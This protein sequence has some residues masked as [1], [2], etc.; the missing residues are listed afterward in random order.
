MHIVSLGSNCYPAT[1]I[2]AVLNSINK[3]KETQ[4]FDM[5]G[6]SMWSINQLIENRFEGIM[7]HHLFKDIV[8][9]EGGGTIV[10]NTR[11]NLRFK[12]DLDFAIQA[13][14]SLSFQAKVNRRIPRLEG[15]F[16]DAKQLL[17]IRY[18]EIQVRRIQHG[19]VTDEY[20]ELCRF[21]TIL[22][23][24][25]HQRNYVIV[26]IT[27]GS[28]GWDEEHRILSV[29]TNALDSP[30]EGCADRISGLISPHLPF[31]R[32]KLDLGTTTVDVKA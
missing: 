14:R 9:M 6:T 19:P 16:R 30:Y 25:Y 24:H 31:L 8:H 23:S 1:Y 22:R 5:V 17:L 18:Q 12:H 32:S 20:E 27:T 2:R 15:I 11:Y 21:T 26:Y 29:H 4:L 28:D 3:T 10:T 7:D 13:R